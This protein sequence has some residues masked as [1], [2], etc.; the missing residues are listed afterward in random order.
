MPFGDEDLSPWFLRN[1]DLSMLLYDEFLLGVWR[2]YFVK[3]GGL[4]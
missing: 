3:L 2:N 1:K 4:Y